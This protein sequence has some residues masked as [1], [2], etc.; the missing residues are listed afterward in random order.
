MKKLLVTRES[1]CLQPI[2]ELIEKQKHR[3]LVS[4]TIECAEHILPIFEEKNSSFATLEPLDHFEGG[5]VGERDDQHRVERAAVAG[6]IPGRLDD[7]YARGLACPP[8][9]ESMPITFCAAM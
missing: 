5:L 4:W 1:A 7:H 2:R 6:P 8:R 3:T 9:I